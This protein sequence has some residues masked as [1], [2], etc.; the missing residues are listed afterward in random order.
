MPSS[1]SPV[2]P[3]HVV[4]TDTRSLWREALRAVIERLDSDITVE[5]VPVPDELAQRVAENGDIG[6]VVISLDTR[7]EKDMRQLERVHRQT[8]DIPIAVIADLL[9]VD[10]VLAVMQRGAKAFIPTTVDSRI[11]IEALRLVAAGGIYV[12][13]LMV[14]VMTSHSAGRIAVDRARGRLGLMLTELSPRQRQVL[15]LIGRG[16]PNKL[17][18]HELEISENTVK[19]HLRQ[20]MK[21]LHVTNRTEAALMALGQDL[22]DFG[23]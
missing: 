20:I 2:R 13:D 3:L 16:K 12:P 4:I 15:K 21:R 14:E 6:V 22:D 5:E 9:D 23:D 18:A 17:I 1:Q 8:P 10:S 7:S 11:M 19:A